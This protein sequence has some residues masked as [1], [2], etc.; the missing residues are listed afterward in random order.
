MITIFGLANCDTCRK[1]RAWLRELGT[2]HRFHD[3]RKDGLDDA[4][5]AGWL[6]QIGADILLNRRGSTWRKLSG[7]DKEKAEDAGVGELL[8]AHPSLIKRPVFVIGGRVM[9]GFGEA[10]KVALAG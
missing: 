10:E 7:A 2:E 6:D 5:V 8:R 4:T 1:A 3:V 9:V